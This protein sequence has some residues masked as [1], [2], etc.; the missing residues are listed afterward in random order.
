MANQVYKKEKIKQKKEVVD[1]DYSKIFLICKSKLF[2]YGRYPYNNNDE[3]CLNKR[4]G[5]YYKYCKIL[6]YTEHYNK[7]VQTIEAEL[8]AIEKY[9][10]NNLLSKNKKNKNKTIY[11]SFLENSF[12]LINNHIKKDNHEIQS[13]YKDN[14]FEIFNVFESQKKKF[15]K[16]ILDSNDNS[17]MIVVIARFKDHWIQDINSFTVKSKNTNKVIKDLFNFLFFKFPIEKNEFLLIYDYS[18]FSDF[19]KTKSLHK[20]LKNIKIEPILTK[21]QINLFKTFNF[22]FD[23]EFFYDYVKHVYIFDII[24]DK[25][26][27]ESLSNEMYNDLLRTYSHFIKNNIIDNPFFDNHEV[28][29]L[30]DYIKIKKREMDNLER[31]FKLESYQL[32][33]LFNE[34]QTWHK[35]LNKSNHKVKKIW[36]SCPFAKGYEIFKYKDENKELT[37]PENVYFNGIVEITTNT[38]LSKEGR[39]LS[40]CV[41]SYSRRCSDGNSF[42]FSLRKKEYTE[43]QVKSLLTIEVTKDK[44][45]VQIRGKKNRL[46]DNNE[47]NIINKWAITEGLKYFI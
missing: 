14:F 30:Y 16:N 8:S 37:D 18:L 39:D 21:K 46:P 23:S 19:L 26:I 24:G 29:P 32:V 40:H 13:T 9:K 7:K 15:I 12:K 2:N 1:N 33:T 3:D 38:D 34:M 20:T 43:K 25:E 11:D 45:I 28:K 5:E 36:N 42:I 44:R 27:A 22:R 41:G 47:K 6:G 4:L 17:L 10:Y 31:D 35:T